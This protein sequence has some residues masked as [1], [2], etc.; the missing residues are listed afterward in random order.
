MIKKKLLIFD[1]DGV[2]VDGMN[3]YWCSA[4]NAFMKIRG[5][6]KNEKRSRYTV[7]VEFRQLRP[8]VNHGWEMVLLAAELSRP[9]SYLIQKGVRS[10]TSNYK[11]Q[12]LE[13]MKHWGWE[14]SDLQT[15]LDQVRN[16]SIR[17]DLNTWLNLHEPFPE[18]IKTLKRLKNEGMKIAILTTKGA[19]FTKQLIDNLGIKV[20]LIYGH[21][22]GSKAEMLLK[23]SDSYDIQG[24]I[25]DR[26]ET[27]Q[28][29][30]EIEKLTKIT[31]YLASWGYLKPQDMQTIHSK[32]NLLTLENLSTPLETW[33]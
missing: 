7:P 31:C 11:E 10:F 19:I 30:I 24:F 8:W 3:E 32:I 2:I 9:N 28:T 27:L 22:S 13:S 12:C 4:K 26:I 16:D 6:S 15:A 17:Q 5:K 25:E 20:D 23:L 1:F 21:E 18:V 14:P 33:S 29:V